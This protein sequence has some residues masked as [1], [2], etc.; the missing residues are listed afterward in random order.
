[1]SQQQK[2]NRQE[3]D[4]HSNAP[5]G[6]IA[7]PLRDRRTDGELAKGFTKPK[8]QS[9]PIVRRSVAKWLPYA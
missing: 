3:P 1:M 8:I 7:S 2:M 9:P 5:P 6:R 4:L